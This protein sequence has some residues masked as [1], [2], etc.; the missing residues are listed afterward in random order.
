MKTKLKFFKSKNG[1]WRWT[2]VARNGKKICTPGESFSSKQAAEKN[3]SRVADA[4]RYGGIERVK[5]E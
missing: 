3:Y 2:L 1:Q 4:F 5:D